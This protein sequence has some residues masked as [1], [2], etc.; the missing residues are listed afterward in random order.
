VPL[1]LV[2]LPA[3]LVLRHCLWGDC[4]TRGVTPKDDEQQNRS[5]EEIQ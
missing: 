5:K 4:H 2:M 3:L 1:F